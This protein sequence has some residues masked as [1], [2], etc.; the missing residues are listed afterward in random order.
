MGNPAFAAALLRDASLF[1]S[2]FSSTVVH[3]GTS[4][5][6]VRSYRDEMVESNGG[7]VIMRRTVLK[8]TAAVAAAIADGDQLTADGTA[9]QV[10]Y[11]QPAPPDGLHVDLI[12]RGG[13]E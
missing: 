5:Q 3:A 7:S 11:R 9:Y 13:G 4:Y 10:D 2:D 6:G 8:V 12:L 1:V